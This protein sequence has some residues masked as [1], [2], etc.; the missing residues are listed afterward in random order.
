MY[1]WAGGYNHIHITTQHYAV[2]CKEL[3]FLE[4]NFPFLDNHLHCS[5]EG[6][7]YGYP[8]HCLR[9]TTIDEFVEWRRYL[10][11]RGNEVG[12]NPPTSLGNSS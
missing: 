5:P 4:D 2:A 11:R 8:T 6:N 7:T 10:M 1:G 3:V 12:R 9:N